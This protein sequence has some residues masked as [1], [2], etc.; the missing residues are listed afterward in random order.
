MNYIKLK[1]QGQDIF[2]Q[3]IMEHEKRFCGYGKNLKEF[4]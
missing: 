1:G 3:S 2:E 4:D